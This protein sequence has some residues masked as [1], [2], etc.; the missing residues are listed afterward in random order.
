MEVLVCLSK[1]APSY[2]L[3]VFSISFQTD[4]LWEQC[5]FLANEIKQTISSSWIIACVHDSDIH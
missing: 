3:H 5:L 1:R 4:R 2:S